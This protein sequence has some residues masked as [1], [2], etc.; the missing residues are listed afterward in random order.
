MQE[1]W[2]FILAIWHHWKVLITGPSMSAL[3]FIAQEPL[4]FN[5]PNWVWW[6]L[7]GITALMAAFLAWRDE[8]RKTEKDDVIYRVR[9]LAEEMLLFL[10]EVGPKPWVRMDKSVSKLMS[11][12]EIWEAGNDVLE[13]WVNKI[14]YDY[15]ARFKTRAIQL[16]DE[17]A[18]RG[19]TDAEIL[20][21]LNT[22]VQ[23]YNGIRTIA[24]RFLGLADKIKVKNL[25]DTGQR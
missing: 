4:R 10:K 22:Q 11:D 19:Y 18:A 25:L 21:H 5:V 7:S 15:S 6:I 20:V 17:L 23:N 13:P 8:H 3:I 24:E 16:K 12:N 2:G 14:H 1:I 9:S